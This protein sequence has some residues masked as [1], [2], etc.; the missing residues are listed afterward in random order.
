MMYAYKTPEGEVVDVEDK[1][2]DAALKAG[3]VPMATL[4]TPEGEEVLVAKE[5]LDAAFKKGLKPP[6]YQSAGPTSDM[7]KMESAARGA[8]QGATL[9]FADEASGVIESIK[10]PL[11]SGTYIKGRD[12]SRKLN[13]MAQAQNP[14]SYL[15]GNV[16]GSIASG[17]AT[18]GIGTAT[19]PARLGMA[20]GQGALAG[21]GGAEGSAS[22]Q[23]KETV[24]GAGLGLA[25]GAVGEAA[26]AGIKALGNLS[27]RKA[28]EAV[29]LRG[30]NAKKLITKKGSTE[31]N[32]LA[33][34]EDMKNLGILDS[35]PEQQMTNINSKLSSVGQKIGDFKQALP[36][37]LSNNQ[38][39]I[40]DDILSKVE[41]QAGMNP[42]AQEALG[43]VATT[44]NRVTK[45][46]D[47][48]RVDEL[49][50]ARDEM[51]KLAKFDKF[52]NLTDENELAR[53]AYAEINNAID[54]RVAQEAGDLA[55][56]SITPDIQK[57]I[58]LLNNYKSLRK[59]NTLLEEAKKGTTG[60]VQRTMYPGGIVG[61]GMGATTG[62]TLGSILGPVGASAGAVV[63]AMVGK[64]IIE[65]LKNPA[66]LS[67]IAGKINKLATKSSSV[68]NMLRGSKNG[69][70]NL[71]TRYINDEAFRNEVD[72]QD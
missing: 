59:E 18:G 3:L 5:H 16:G 60:L 20:A 21:L 23:L 70:T 46:R 51:A 28:L 27:S 71:L 58:D 17:I 11:T 15:A 7:T 62:A 44:L 48:V 65:K 12:E 49:N 67:M 43:R 32:L 29:N 52:D 19:M 72:A 34:G 36:D 69:L 33:K 25:G 66:M 13:E 38:F 37:N 40:V 22:N 56:G 53:K 26:G 41:Q 55:Q 1:N 47:I 68:N 64:Q 63:G 2:V 45:G 6:M 42:T 4:V 54:A 10:N 30:T 39:S 61:A 9:G 31:E 50:Q 8:L 14:G 57:K 35:N 24:T